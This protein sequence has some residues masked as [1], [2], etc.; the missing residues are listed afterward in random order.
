MRDTLASFTGG[1]IV[2]VQQAAESPELQNQFYT[3]QQLLKNQFGISDQGQATR[4]LDLLAGLDEAGRTGDKDTQ[5][6]L[7]K[8]LANEM[9]SRDKTLDEWEKANR[10]LEVQS[11]LLAVIARPGLMAARDVARQGREYMGRGIDYAGKKAREGAKAT[12]RMLNIDEESSTAKII[13]G[14]DNPND[15]PEQAAALLGANNA[16]PISGV[17][18]STTSGPSMDSYFASVARDRTNAAIGRGG[19][20]T[21]GLTPQEFEQQQ[22]EML[23]QQ[24]MDMANRPI[25]VNISL[26][27]A[28][29]QHVVQ[30]VLADANKINS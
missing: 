21:G 15:Q 30:S 17:T 29:G 4:V 18:P 27:N 2:T 8:Q 5:A 19:S 7:Q 26:E 11:N 13:M 20:G 10:Q 16:S 14:M 12:M 9:D 24:A 25:N 22:L 23:R 3:Q 28:A 6:E 1:D